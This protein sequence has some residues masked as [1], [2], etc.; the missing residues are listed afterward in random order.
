MTSV[1]QMALAE[2]LHVSFVNLEYAQMVGDDNVAP[3][4]TQLRELKLTPRGQIMHS[5]AGATQATIFLL[6]RDVHFDLLEVCAAESAEVA[7]VWDNEVEQM[8]FR[9]HQVPKDHACGW[10]STA[11]ALNLARVPCPVELQAPPLSDM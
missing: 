7:Y 9:L 3:G 1:H 4:K 5:G 10:T 8:Y 2:R 11:R 6:Y